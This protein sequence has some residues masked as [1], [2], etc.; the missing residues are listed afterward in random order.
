MARATNSLAFLF[1]DDTTL[2]LSSPNIAELKIHGNREL[3][4]VSTW[5]RSNKLTLNVSKTKYIIFH[6][7]NMVI[8]NNEFSIKI[9]DEIIERI[10]DDLQ[11][12]SYKFL[13]LHIDERLSW[14]DHIQNVCNKVSSGNYALARVKNFLPQNIRLTLYN[15]LIR[16]H[17]EYGIVAWGGAKIS[18]VRKLI[19]SQKKAVRNVAGKPSRH[20]SEPLF[21]HL[22]LLKFSDLFRYNCSLFMFRYTYSLLPPSFSGIFSPLSQPNRTLNYKLP[23]S[24]NAFVDQLP[25][26]VLPRIWNSLERHLKTSGSLNIFKKNLYKMIIDNYS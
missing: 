2:Q 6:S 4:K 20:S 25:A 10:G 5:I 1:A 15:S 18:H 24:K 12:K 21:S 19:I 16:P 8:P 7:K 23:R 3:E 17:L 13:G 9:N 22:E 11:T 14:S 26:A